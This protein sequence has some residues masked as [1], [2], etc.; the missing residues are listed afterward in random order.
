MRQDLI[1]CL[2][3]IAGA[4]AF[5]EN[6]IRE[7]LVRK[8]LA[9]KSNAADGRVRPMFANPTSTVFINEF[10][11]DDAGTDANEFIEVAAPAGTNMANYSIVLYNGATG[12]E[13][14]RTIGI[15][16]SNTTSTVD[17]HGD[18]TSEGN[19]A[20]FV[21]VTNVTDAT[22]TVEPKIFVK[23]LTVNGF[24]STDTCY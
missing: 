11:Y 19:E 14:G 1:A 22:V 12:S 3:L 10:H 9:E 24:K 21:N 20:F 5:T 7:L 8:V 23:Q 17:V 2:I 16:S 4:I 6:P 13:T 18:L 15:G